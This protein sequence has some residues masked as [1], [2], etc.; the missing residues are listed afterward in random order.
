MD[1]LVLDKYPILTAL[2][3][4][5]LILVV[6]TVVYRL[7]KW[8][9]VKFGEKAVKK[10]ATQLDDMLL[11]FLQ[12]FL[13]RLVGVITL[14]FVGKQLPVVSGEVVFGYFSKGLYIVAV[15][16]V[17]SLVI[18]L[19][20]LIISYYLEKESEKRGSELQKDF[21]LLLHRLIQITLYLTATITI[22]TYLNVD[23]KGLVATLGVGSLAIALAAQET[24]SNMIAGFVI[25]VDRPFRVGDR[26]K[27]P[28]NVTGTV[29]HIGLRS[30]K[31][32][33]FDKNIHV[34]P[35]SQIVK[36]EIV[37]YSYP[38]PSVRVRIAV[39]VAYGSDLNEVK[40]ILVETATRHPKVL[41]DPEPRAFFIQF[42]PSSLDLWLDSYVAHY[43]DAWQTGDEIRMAVYEAL[44]KHNIEIPFQQHVVHIKKETE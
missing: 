19:L 31:L 2:A 40:R 42:G 15:L 32:Q 30:M 3:K 23:V 26:I 43:Q 38:D 41:K 18:R 17:T 39:G 9:L 12:K 20:R 35:N 14:Y 8:A 37:N 28:Q 22:L 27:T 34:I 5:A 1:W 10:T 36:L 16:V 25:M 33:D 29:V 13:F 11:E 7:L 4:A 21:G 24:L 44:N 6:A